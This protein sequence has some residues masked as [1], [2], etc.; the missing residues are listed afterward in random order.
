MVLIIAIYSFSVPKRVGVSQ[1]DD[2][3]LMK[4]INIVMTVHFDWSRSSS[5]SKFSKMAPPTKV[6]IVKKNQE[7]FLKIL[8][9][10]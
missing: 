6:I 9:V 10:L 1:E 2:R 4:N 3:L 7:A 8:W 5:N